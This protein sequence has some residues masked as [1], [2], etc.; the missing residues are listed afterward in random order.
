MFQCF[1]EQGRRAALAVALCALAAPAFAEKAAPRPKIEVLRDQARILQRFPKDTGLVRHGVKIRLRTGDWLEVT[2]NPFGPSAPTL[3]WYAP[4]LHLAGVCQTGRGVIVT[5]LIELHSGR[6]ATAPGLPVLRPERGLIA[7]GPDPAR[8]ADADSLTLVQVEDRDLIDEGG[9][10]F[11]DDYGPGAW[12]DGDCYRLTPK[13][14][15]AAAWLEKTRAGWQEV[16]AAQSA[17]CQGR[18]AK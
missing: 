16:P 14:G 3:C 5:T 8:G 17:V 15:K 11:D 13:T 9:A 18:H 12:V 1:G 4:A 10:L 2:D 7:I 6:R